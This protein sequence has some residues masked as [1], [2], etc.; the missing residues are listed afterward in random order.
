LK[1]AR[2]RPCSARI[3]ELVGARPSYGYR[4]VTALLNRELA[5][6]VN[7]KRIYRIMKRN[8]LLLER[9]TGDGRGR[10]HDG[11]IITL[12]PNLRWCSDSFEIRCWSGERVFVAFVLDSCDREVTGFVAAPGPLCGEHVRDMM[13][14]A[15]E[16]R[17]GAET[18]HLAVPIEWLSDNGSI[19][20]SDET[21]AFGAEIG[22]EMCTTPPY[23][24]ESNGMAESFVKA[25]S[26]TTCTSPTS[27]RQP[28]CCVTSL[29]GLTT[30]TASA[31]TKACECFHLLNSG[32]LNW[33]HDTGSGPTGATPGAGGLGGALGISGASGAGGSAG[34]GGAAGAVGQQ[35]A[36]RAQAAARAAALSACAA[37]QLCD[38]FEG[39]AP[40]DAASAWKV[41]KNGGYT[42]ETVTTQ[43]HSGTHSVHAMAS[44]SSGYA[45]IERRRRFRRPTFGA[46]HSCASKP[47]AAVTKSSRGLDTNTNE[48]Q[49]EQVR[50]LNNL[51][52]GKITTN[53]RSDDKSKP[54]APRSRWAPGSA[55]SGTSRQPPSK[56]SRR[57]RAHGRRRTL[58]RADVGLIGAR[59]RAL[60][61][62]HAGRCLDRRRRD[63]LDA[64]GCN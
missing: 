2:T 44:G 61:R 31:R 63:Q 36:L 43:A 8:K 15:V 42:L 35:R 41:I 24:P 7:P 33:H 21:R 20:T 53:R 18:R 54:P 25:S 46:G 11:K 48:A 30:T 40:G 22:F 26:A 1:Q 52:G 32:T 19:Y 16:H 50:L 37:F 4:R 14:Q 17:F 29:L 59:F 23:S 12:K 39:V 10:K 34:A 6:R 9:C 13:V 5:E 27:G 56:I 45:Y 47:R 28:T 60:L 38:D 58:G 57:Q 3:R 51:G 62:R 55:T 64:V 49:G